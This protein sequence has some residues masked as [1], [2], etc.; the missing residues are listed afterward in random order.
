MALGPWPLVLGRWT[1]GPWPLALGSWPCDILLLALF[2]CPNCPLRVVLCAKLPLATGPM[3][4]GPSPLATTPWPL[5]TW[6][7][8]FEHWG[9]AL[10]AIVAIGELCPVA[11]ALGPMPPWP[12]AL[13]GWPLDLGHGFVANLPLIVGPCPWPQGL[14]PWPLALK[15]VTA[16]QQQPS[17]L[18]MTPI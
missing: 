9:Y 11:L 13:D 1:F 5:A 2:W 14:G 7:F 6:P 8:D 17:S 10:V 18:V 3:Y 12:L 4:L 15:E 16:K